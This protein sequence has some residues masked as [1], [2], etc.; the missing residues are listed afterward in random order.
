VTPLILSDSEPDL[1]HAVEIEIVRWGRDYEITVF[2]TVDETDRP[3]AQTVDTYTLDDA[4][5]IG[6]ELLR[7]VSIARAAQDGRQAELP[8]GEVA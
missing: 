1:T 8:L 2:N 6:L 4:E 3:L 5:R 7:A